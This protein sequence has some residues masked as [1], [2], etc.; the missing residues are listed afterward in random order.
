M[1]KDMVDNNAK[2]HA[3]SWLDRRMWA[4]A[5]TVE[6]AASSPDLA[7]D[8]WHD[9]YDHSG[10]RSDSSSTY[11]RQKRSF[12]GVFSSGMALVALSYEAKPQ[13]RPSSWLAP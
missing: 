1:S 13:L 4:A 9:T 3:V 10:N 2:K 8:S 7:F 6:S 5:A 11:E 12:I